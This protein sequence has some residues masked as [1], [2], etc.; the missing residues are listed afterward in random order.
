MT[1]ITFFFLYNSVNSIPVEKAKNLFKRLVMKKLYYKN[2]NQE[3]L[4][5][6]VKISAHYMPHFCVFKN[7]PQLPEV[8]TA[9][10]RIE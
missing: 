5:P 9:K 8:I 10:S 2:L 3:A 1:I 4:F 6:S 7:T